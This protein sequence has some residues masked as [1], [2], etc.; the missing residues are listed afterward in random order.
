MVKRIGRSKKRSRKKLTKDL[1]SKGKISI[2]KYF[3]QFSKGDAVVLKAEPAVQSGMYDMMFHGR[4]A[5]VEGK[6]GACYKVVITD[7][8][9]KKMLVVHPIHLKKV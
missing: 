3:A 1:R 5:I 8:S 7:G 4:R 2:S 6:Q 9:K